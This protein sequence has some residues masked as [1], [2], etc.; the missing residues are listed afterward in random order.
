[1][2]IR[3][4]S[5]TLPSRF[6]VGTKRRAA[7]R[8]L[9]GGQ[10]AERDLNA[11]WDRLRF[12]LNVS[13]VMIYTAKAH[14]DYG[15]TFISANVA[16]QLGY[17]PEQFLE[18]SSFWV[19]HLHPDDSQRVLEE[20][21]ELL[22][23]GEY[24]LE[25]RFLHKD[26]SYRWM[27]DDA[28]LVRDSDD[29]G[30]EIAGCWLD[31]T[32]RKTIE[33]QLAKQARQLEEA[34]RV[35]LVGSWDWDIR[36]DTITWSDEHYR[37]FGL[38]PRSAVNGYDWVAQRIH[39]DDRQRMRDAIDAAWTRM[40][41]YNIELRV[42]R[43]DGAERHICSRGE[44]VWDGAGRPIGM[45]GTVQDI[46]EH[47]NSEEALYRSEQQVR[48]VLEEREQL[49]QDLHDSTMQTM[50]AV[51]LSLEE[52][53]R[54]LGSEASAALRTITHA[55]ERLNGTLQDIRKFI[56]GQDSNLTSAQLCAEL[57]DFAH[58]VTAAQLSRFKLDIDPLAASKLMPDEARHVLYIAREAMSNSLRHSRARA[59]TLSLR[60]YRGVVRLEV[61]DNGIGFKPQQARRQG[62]GLRNMAARA[63]QLGAK[64][65]VRSKTGRGTSVILEIP[66]KANRS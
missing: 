52:C 14:G 9:A 10:R 62:R 41:P 21:T 33:A 44:V 53:K 43:P 64:I 31:I 58:T 11:T 42:V 8:V 47:K 4:A 13:P 60:C 36:S 46:T 6:G 3:R 39:P 26:G 48:R 22:Q 61:T 56:V 12:L 24:V 5:Y 37:I 34:Q 17:Q 32:Q 35:A 63:E 2:T 45:V 15:V 27:R 19:N 49:S 1:M 30:L 20:V 28:R 23:K 54:L 57:E 51:G 25:Y 66:K 55:I 50:Y 29:S 18:D 65:A 40:K 38:P 16:A 59:G 7:A